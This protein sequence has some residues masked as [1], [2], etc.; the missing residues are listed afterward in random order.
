MVIRMEN[1]L[2]PVCA[3]NGLQRVTGAYRTEYVGRDGVP[4]PLCVSNVNWTECTKCGEAIL[5]D[6][7]TRAIE[8]ARSQAQGLLS[9]QEI[10]N[11]RQ[12]LQK[13][14]TDMSRLLGIG[15]KTYC[16]WESGA[17]T[18]SVAFDRYLRLLIA[19]HANVTMLESIEAGS[20]VF[21]ADMEEG[22]SRIELTFT[23]LSK[24]EALAELEENFTELLSSGEL[25]AGVLPVFYREPEE[26]LS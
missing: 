9:P 6:E 3:K 10:K 18:Q 7:T 5:D 24:H 22:P 12:S 16:R 26:C 1:T 14:Q 4:R 11:F 25:Q 13:T 8:V 21:E 23:L 20:Y 19:E 2:C 17:Y 15:K